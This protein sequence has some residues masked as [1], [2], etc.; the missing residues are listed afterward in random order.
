VGAQPP[1]Q[2]CFKVCRPEVQQC[3]G[4]V[5]QQPS[6]KLKYVSTVPCP[7]LWL[8]SLILAGLHRRAPQRI[9]PLHP[10]LGIP[11][12]AH[13]THDWH[14]ASSESA[15]LP[16]YLAQLPGI[17]QRSPRQHRYLHSIFFSATPFPIPISL[18]ATPWLIGI[19]WEVTQHQT[20]AGV[21]HRP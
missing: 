19:Y 8:D 5:L 7:G 1:C 15:Q 13:P 10:T 12:N 17:T 20:I 14:T 4:C 11:Q 21:Q 3:P 6:L 16:H 2:V 9:A 18:L